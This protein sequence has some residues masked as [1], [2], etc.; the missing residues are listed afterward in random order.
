MLCLSQT[1]TAQPKAAKKSEAEFL[2]PPQ[3]GAF[4]IPVHSG[5]VCILSFPEKMSS[6]ALASSPDFEI[7][8]WGDDGVAVRAIGT[9]AKTTTLALATTTGGI[10]VNVTLNVV[11]AATEAL[12]LVRFKSATSDDAFQ[13]Q[14]AEAV[15]KKLAPLEAELA[16]AR[17]NVDAQIRDRADGLIA[18]RLLKRNEVLQLTSHERNDDH[19][20]AHVTRALLIGDDGYVMFEIENRS[21]SAYRL[22][23]VEV[24]A[25]DK[26]VAGPARLASSSV[27]RDAS[28]I[29]VIAAGATA[30]G[31]V[32]VRSADQV[33]GKSLT[34]V[35]ADPDGTGAIRL[36]RGIV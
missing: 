2:V 22:A 9:G 10:K 6:K 24:R 8:A 15:A 18:E 25:S 5:E 14:V 33:L 30:R 13:A 36:D 31:S 29:G 26:N 3:G 20:I 28:V 27:D 19:V 23:K 32:V 34:L 12:T 11:P 7:K 35:L 21:S 1:G 4:Q 16:K 17:Q